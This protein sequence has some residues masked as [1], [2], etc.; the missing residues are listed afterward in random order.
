MSNSVK[1]KSSVLND[2]RVQVIVIEQIA[3]LSGVHSPYKT[4]DTGQILMAGDNPER[5][6]KV[7]RSDKSA[8]YNSKN[9]VEMPACSSQAES[10]ILVENS[11]YDSE[12][13]VLG[14]VS[15]LNEVLFEHTSKQVM[16]K[17]YTFEKDKRFSSFKV[18]NK[19]QGY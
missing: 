8:W 10:K 16:T 18:F 13:K 1:N 3:G 9:L 12:A 6:Y 14:L 7:T 11:V 2:A 5:Q 15:F 19:K 17:F 4:D